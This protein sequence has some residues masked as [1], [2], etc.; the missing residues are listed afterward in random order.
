MNAIYKITCRNGKIYVGQDRTNSIGYF[1][2]RFW[3]VGSSGSMPALVVPPRLLWG[4]SVSFE[5]SQ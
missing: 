3:E 1:G 4:A 2:A 5:R